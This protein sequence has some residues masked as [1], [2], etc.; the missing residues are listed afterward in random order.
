M[1]DYIEIAN[2]IRNRIHPESDSLLLAGSII[3]N[4][5]TKYSDL[6]IVVI[7]KSMPK[8]YRESFIYDGVLVETFV[9]D[10]ETVDYFLNKFDKCNSSSTLAQMIVEGIEIPYSTPLLR[11]IKKEA[12]KYI[13]AGPN[14]LNKQNIDNMRYAITNLID[15]IRDS[16]NEPEL[17]GTMSSLY[18]S[19][20]DFYFKAN[21]C[22]AGSDKYI[23]RLLKKYDV[24]LEKKF[25]DAFSTAIRDV[26]IDKVIEIAEDILKPFGGFLFD[27][28]RLDATEEMRIRKE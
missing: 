28:Y 6:D 24:N 11:E 18:T 4:E 1:I 20:S 10:P 26:N 16:K 27:G 9:H 14:K 17:L 3:R 2:E 13:L 19:L 7:Y 5:G 23:S 25:F 15:D 8:A 22:W 12:N 21:G